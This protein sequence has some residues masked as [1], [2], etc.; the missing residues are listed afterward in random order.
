[1]AYPSRAHQSRQT[2]SWSS[3]E[4]SRCF[5]HEKRA[6]MTAVFISSGINPYVL[7][8]Y[9]SNSTNLMRICTDFFLTTFNQML[10]YELAIANQMRTFKEDYQ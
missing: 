5:E 3:I 9:A 8:D 2:R 1:M 10:Y 4:A 6:Y 7:T